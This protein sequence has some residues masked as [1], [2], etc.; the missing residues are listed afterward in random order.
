M[1]APVPPPLGF[2]VAPAHQDP[3]RPW[4]EPVAIAEAWR[5]LPGLASSPDVRSWIG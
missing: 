1:R 2:T 3:M 4:F 5:L